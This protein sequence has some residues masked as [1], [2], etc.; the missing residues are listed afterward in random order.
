MK[1]RVFL[2]SIFI[3]ILLSS[4][5]YFQTINQPSISA[6]NEVITVSIIT[7]TEGGGEEPYFGVCLPI[8]WTIPG[9]SIQCSGVYNEVIYYDSLVTF[10]QR[11]I[12]PEK[13]G[14]YWWAGKGIP[15]STF[16][17]NVYAEL[18]IQTDNQIGFFSIDYMLGNSYNGVNQERSNGHI[19][20][21]TTEPVIALVSPNVGYQN[22][23]MDVNLVGLNT[24]FTDGL[25]TQ[26]VWLSQN[27][28]E[29]YANSF[30]VN[31][32][33]SL[34]ANFSIP[35][36]A[37][38]GLW[39][40]NVETDIDGVITKLDGFEIFPPIPVIS[41]TPDSI[42]IEV[43]P[44]TKRTKTLMISNNGW[45]DLLFDIGYKH[46]ALQFNGTDSYVVCE[47]DSSLNIEQSI[48]VEAWIYPFDWYGNRR[49]LQKEINDNQYRFLAEG[50]F[51]F[52]V[53]YV[54]N[55][56]ITAPLPSTNEWHHVAGVY[57]Y[58][59]SIM[60]LFIDGE[61]VAENLNVTGMINTSTDPLYI[62]TKFPGAPSG[63]YFNGIID[64]IRIWSLARTE[65]EIQEYL[66]QELI[67]TEQGLEGYWQFNEG[68]GDTTFDKTSNSNNGF[69][70]GGVSWVQSLAPFTTIAGWIS[71]SPDSGICYPD[72]SMEIV[73]TFDATELDTG[74][75]YTALLIN[76]NDPLHNSI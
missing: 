67:G 45:N 71:A 6:P 12:S 53:R 11:S 48:T 62:G 31:S 1:K 37:P 23:T 41:V 59:S 18:K 19:I 73:I 72:S 13:D 49:I 69:L 25:G 26:N 52:D 17:G 66:N 3:L 56:E 55:G 14:Y 15:V 24:H 63:D 70:Q 35:L 7:N 74:D 60:Q 64:E 28:N 36:T 4:C 33:T 22:Y 38:L 47:D 50:E 58:E 29:I 8:G 43:L 2:I 27:G 21:I 40:V 20:E 16:I 42:Y 57:D 51:K 44:G 68:I 76:S 39:D 10:E 46:F 5:I 65:A 32:N 61:K 9:D 34:V 54:N 30:V 75:Y